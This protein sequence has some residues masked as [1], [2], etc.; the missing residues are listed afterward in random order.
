MATLKIPADNKILYF[1]RDRADFA[2]LSHF[3]A[4]PIVL[5]GTLWPTVEHFYQAQK[6]FD[7]DYRAAVMNAI[8]PGAAKRL[9]TNPNASG[10]GSEY[11]WFKKN[12]QS[13]RPDWKDV[14]LHV[15]RRADL[16]KF[17]QHQDL[18]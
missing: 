10:K 1:R 14:K 17:S 7:P 8:S 16:A 9:A 6:S 4:A 5:D 3:Y 15:M 2:F 18:R 12:G 11:S 13:P